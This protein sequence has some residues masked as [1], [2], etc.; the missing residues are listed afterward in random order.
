MLI[1][2]KLQVLD[3]FVIFRPPIQHIDDCT[4][5]KYALQLNTYRYI[6]RH[7]YGIDV[8]EMI[9][10]SFHPNLSKYFAIEVP[11]SVVLIN[12]NSVMY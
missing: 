5:S 4:G 12:V 9:I 1:T 2:I 8:S 11:V 7:Y 3:L 6:L 10:A